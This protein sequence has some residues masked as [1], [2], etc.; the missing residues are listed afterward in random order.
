MLLSAG[1]CT[2]EGIWTPS[3]KTWCRDE[4]LQSLIHS[5]IYQP[6]LQFTSFRSISH[7]NSRLCHCRCHGRFIH[8][9]K[10]CRV[11]G[12]GGKLTVHIRRFCCSCARTAR[13]VRRRRTTSSTSSSHSRRC[14]P[15]WP[16]WPCSPCEIL[17][18]EP[19]PRFGLVQ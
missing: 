19:S 15:C 16:C 7:A 11:Q 1:P 9:A 18:R 10:L 8:I 2:S 4:A 12:K 13:E 5:Y 3:K 17:Q 6:I 14:W